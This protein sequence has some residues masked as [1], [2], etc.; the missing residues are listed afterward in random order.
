MRREW[1]ARRRRPPTSLG[2]GTPRK[3]SGGPIARLAK[4]ASQAPWRLPAL[5]FPFEGTDKGE[6]DAPGVLK[7]TGRGALAFVVE[8]ISARVSER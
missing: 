1:S 8:E 5:H 6:A 4:G 2:D 7:N 3:L